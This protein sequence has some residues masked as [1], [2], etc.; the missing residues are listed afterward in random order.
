MAAR[1]TETNRAPAPGLTNP[2]AV[3]VTVAEISGAARLRAGAGRE[4]HA[5]SQHG[6]PRGGGPAGRRNLAG[7]SAG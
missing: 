2:A 5:D 7:R 4:L 3:S 1:S 6:R